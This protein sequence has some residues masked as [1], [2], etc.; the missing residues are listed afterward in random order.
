MVESTQGVPVQT[1]DDRLP[2]IGLEEHVVVPELLAAWAKIPGLPQIPELGFGDEQMARRLRDIG[3]R[4]LAEMDDQGVDVQVLSCTTPGVQNLAPDDAVE[5]ARE[6]N[7]ALSSAVSRRPDRFQAFATLPTP[8]P[9][10]AAEELERAVTDL[11]MRGAMIFGRS[12]R[13][14]EARLP[15]T[16]RGVAEQMGALTLG[17]ANH[18]HADDRRFDTLYVTAER[19]GVPL[20]LHPQQ[21]EAAVKNAYYSGF[22]DQQDTSFASAGLG[23]Y[24]DN[25]IELLRLILS[26]VFDRYP[27]LQVIVGHWGEL[28]LFYLDH[29]AVMQTMGFSLDRPLVDYFRQNIWITGSGLSS[30]RYFRWAAEVVG[31]D[32]IMFSTDYPYTYDSDYPMLDTAGGK[33]R[34][35]LDDLPV[36][37]AEK[38]AIAA[39]NWQRLMAPVS[40]AVG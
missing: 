36:T 17:L 31:I 3:D 30:Q 35:F 27:R 40:A 39:G 34:A 22:G 1:G 10:R 28:V 8:D 11:G 29:I 32:R 13:V 5:V 33:A 23:W 6:A 20:Y 16:A 14:R 2:I 4:R 18:V 26:G 19:L 12:G 38:R 25:G 7:D 24:Y 21:P 15:D 37:A 9:D